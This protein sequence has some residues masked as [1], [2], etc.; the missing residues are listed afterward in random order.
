MHILYRAITFMVFSIVTMMAMAGP[1]DEIN[2]IK[3]DSLYVYGEATKPTTSEAYDAALNIL[4]SNIQQWFE[5]SKKDR[6]NRVVRNLTFLADTINALRGDYHRVLA[7][8]SIPKLES[9]IE[10]DENVEAEAKKGVKPSII[11]DN[12]TLHSDP[13]M[14]TLLRTLVSKPTFRDFAELIMKN[15]NDGIISKASRDITQE[16]EGSFLAIFTKN[17]KDYILLH[18]L[19]PGSNSRLDLVTGKEFDADLFIQNRDTYRFLWF[20]LPKSK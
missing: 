3:R 1:V 19:A 14:D 2:K 15:R 11:S 12:K 8:V 6:K 13:Q 5:D 9:T 16:A 4:Q 10:N 18:L 20:V 7:Y 17:K